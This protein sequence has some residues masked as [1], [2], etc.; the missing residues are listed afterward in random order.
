MEEINK[1]AEA[2]ITSHSSSGSKCLLP[3]YRQTVE[4]GEKKCR[5]ST[6]FQSLN[7]LTDDDIVR[8]ITSIAKQISL[9]TSMMMDEIKLVECYAIGF[10][11]EHHF[12]QNVRG[13]TSSLPNEWILYGR[14]YEFKH[15]IELLLKEPNVSGNVSVIPI[16]GMGG[17]GKTALAQF[18]F[19]C[20]AIK[21][22]FDKKAWICVSDCFNCFNRDR[23][24]KEILDSVSIGDGSSQTVPVGITTGLVLLEREIKRQLIGKRFLLVLDDVWSQD[25]QQLLDLLQFAHAEAIKV[26][27]TCRDPKTLGVL[28][29]GGNQ[30]SLKGL[31]DEDSYLLFVKCLYR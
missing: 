5:L 31:S 11:R 16:V 25:W 12:T 23:I 3:F 30:I 28:G 27:V 19:N 15:L 14:D 18:V 21:N 10:P 26:V 13:T 1:A 2:D 17:I 29:Y 20:T 24:I 9:I 8:K 6:S 22:H 7:L 4:S